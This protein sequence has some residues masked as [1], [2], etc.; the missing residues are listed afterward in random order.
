MNARKN[1]VLSKGKTKMVEPNNE[2]DKTYNEASLN[3]DEASLGPDEASPGPNEATPGPDVGMDLEPDW[4]ENEEEE[5]S[6]HDEIPEGIDHC[7]DF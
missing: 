1:K 6:D 5:G 3:P 7:E 4:A 2:R